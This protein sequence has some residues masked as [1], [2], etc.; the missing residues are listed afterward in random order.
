VDAVGVGILLVFAAVIYVCGYYPLMR[1]HREYQEKQAALSAQ[2]EHSARLESALLAL[3]KRLATVSRT[4]ATS[5]LNL[6]PAANLNNQLA[7]ISSLAAES[8]LTLGDVRTD[9]P[10]AESHSDAFPV[11]LAGKGTYRACTVFLSCLRKTFPDTTIVAVDLS[12]DADD[13]SGT[14]KFDYRL[15]WHAAPKPVAVPAK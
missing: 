8:G 10:V 6:K 4:L 3:Q 14:G 1:S 9:Q 13:T 11:R 2:Q 7:Q 15:R 5:S 12:G